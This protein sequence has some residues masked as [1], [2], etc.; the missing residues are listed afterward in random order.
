MFNENKKQETSEIGKA[1]VIKACRPLSAED[2]VAENYGPV[3][4]LRTVGQRQRS[5]QGRYLFTCSCKAC[6]QDW[7]TLEN[8]TTSFIK[9]RCPTKTCQSSFLYKEGM[10]EWKCN[11]C[12]NKADVRD[13]CRLYASYNKDFEE[14][15]PL[16]EE[17]RLEEAASA[18]V[19]FIEEMLLLVR[20]PSKNVH[21]AQEALRTCWANEGNV[22]VLP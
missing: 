11:Q 20:P 4:T 1:I 9:F 13:L 21:L 8:L 3:F 17:G 15:V 16:M 7:P 6:Q 22:F 14:A 18:M 2:T 19:K 5:L 10:K 12:K